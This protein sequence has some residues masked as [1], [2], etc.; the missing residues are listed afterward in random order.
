MCYHLLHL[1]DGRFYIPKFGQLFIFGSSVFHGF[2]SGSAGFFCVVANAAQHD[3]LRR[4]FQTGEFDHGHIVAVFL[5]LQSA[6][7]IG[8]D[9]G[10][11]FLRIPCF[12]IEAFMSFS[13]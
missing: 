1:A 12:R 13:I 2:L 8:E 4:M 6:E 5:Q 3:I 7:A 9:G 11:A 10:D